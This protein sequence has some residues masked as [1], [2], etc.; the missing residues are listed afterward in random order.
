MIYVSCIF[1][2]AAVVLLLIPFLKTFQWFLLVALLFGIGYGTFLSIDYA[3]TVDIL[4][5]T[6]Q[7]GK[8][9]GVYNLSITIP[10]IIAPIISGLLLDNF[11]RVGLSQ[12]I[13][14]LGYLIVYGL[15]I[16]CFIFS[17]L[18]IIPIKFEN[19]Y[20]GRLEEYFLSK[21]TEEMHP[22]QYN[23]RRESYGQTREGYHSSRYQ[24]QGER[25]STEEGEENPP[26]YIESDEDEDSYNEDKALNDFVGG[27]I[28]V[29]DLSF[30]S[31]DL[32][33]DELE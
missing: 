24:E 30:G 26:H 27:K 28:D 18:F 8:D 16:L 14:Q 10:Q 1:E 21:D 3:L 12:N 15:S 32:S 6:H 22:V 29:D 20:R 9:L 11:N 33:D 25:Q 17:A 4:P 19:R 31:D 23:S 7:F 5:S 2:V 13:P